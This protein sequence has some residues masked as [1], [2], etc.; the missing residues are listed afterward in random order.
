MSTNSQPVSDWGN[1]LYDGASGVGVFKADLTMIVAVIFGVLLVVCGLYM[2]MYNND[3]NYLHIKGQVV[4]PNCTTAGVTTDSHGKTITSYK[5]NLGVKYVINGKEYSKT[6]FVNGTANYVAN[7]P[8]D[9][10]VL[11]SDFTNVQISQISSSTMGMMMIAVAIVLVV[12]AYINYYLTHNYKVFAATQGVST[13]TGL[14][15]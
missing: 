11:K 14:F 12:A 3:A 6:I 1:S 13:L 15:R 8:I 2:M 7:E 5:C 4:T 10:M 9:L